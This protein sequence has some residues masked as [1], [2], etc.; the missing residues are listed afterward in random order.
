MRKMLNKK[1]FTLAELLIVVAIIAVLVAISIPV[2]TSQLKKS[3]IAVTEAN[4]RSAKAAA[5]ADYIT[6]L[7]ANE[8]K[9]Q[10]NLWAWINE[11]LSFSLVARASESTYTYRH[12]KDTYAYYCYEN[13]KLNLST[14][15]NPGDKVEDSGSKK[16]EK[17]YVQI[18]TTDNVVK[19]CPYIDSSGDVVITGY[20]VSVF[21]GST[22]SDGNGTGNQNNN[23]G[24][25]GEDDE[26]ESGHGHSG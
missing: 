10:Q 23:S 21:G 22:G 12:D 13:G 4:I 15:F 2:F 9:T 25:S 26:E 8:E 7:S 20:D 19:T 1:G 3:E 11:K 17:I 6:T 18:S 14:S 5:M 16:Y 24:T